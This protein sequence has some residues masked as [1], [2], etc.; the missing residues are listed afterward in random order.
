MNRYSGRGVHGHT[1]EVLGARIVSGELLP[2]DTLDL[3]SIGAELGVSLTA[4]REAIKVLTARGLLDARQ[5]RGTFV[6]PRKDWNLLDSEV[7]RWR[8]ATGERD[9][10]LRDL[11]EIRETIEPSAAS[12]AAQRRD[13]DD[14]AALNAA[15]TAMEDAGDGTAAEIAEADLGF[16]QTILRATHNE[17]FS[18]MSVFV[19]PALS[20]RDELLHGHPVEDPLPSHRR[21]VKAIVEAD[22]EAAADAVRALLEQ[23]VV[24]AALLLETNEGSSTS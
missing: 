16:H 14:I 10:L 11:A 24:D 1:V 22:P 19:D 13:D 7:I 5:K 4:L 8:Y 6:R 15:L 9:V 21:V 2:G 12:I 17:L 3:P 20:L 18:R 23:S